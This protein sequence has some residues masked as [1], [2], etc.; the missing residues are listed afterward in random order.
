MRALTARQE[1]SFLCMRAWLGDG[2]KI[3]NDSC[4]FYS[5]AVSIQENT[6]YTSIVAYADHKIL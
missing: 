1:G 5:R 3:F 4:G 6:W 2:G